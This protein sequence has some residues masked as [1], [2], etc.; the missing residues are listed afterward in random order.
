MTRTA[1][2]FQLEHVA[3]VNG[4]MVPRP[5]GFHSRSHVRA[6]APAADIQDQ[7]LGQML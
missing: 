6:R 2:W 3:S 7:R 4:R 5:F 1:K